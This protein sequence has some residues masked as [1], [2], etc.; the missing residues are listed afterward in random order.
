MPPSVAAEWSE[1]SAQHSSSVA[2]EPSAVHTDPLVPTGNAEYLKRTVLPLLHDALEELSGILVQERLQIATG[3]L[4]EDGYR[5]ESWN[6]VDPLQYLTDYFRRAP[7]RSASTAVRAACVVSRP[8][9]SR[10]LRNPRAPRKARTVR[11]GPSTITS[12]WQKR[13]S[14][15]WHEL[16]KEE[17]LEACFRCGSACKG[18]RHRGEEAVPS[19][20]GPGR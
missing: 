1:L 14:P 15:L 20:D 10:R 3:E 5:P 16:S 6:A 12:V 9:R 11:A 4:W 8:P 13:N 2:D 17:K 19:S 18:S 7:G